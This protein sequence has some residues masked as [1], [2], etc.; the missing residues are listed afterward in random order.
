MLMQPGA[1]INILATHGEGKHKTQALTRQ[2][3]LLPKQF[4]ASPLLPTLR[5]ELHFFDSG[6]PIDRLPSFG[7][8]HVSTSTG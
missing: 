8:G 2:L 4:S 6:D 3:F 5:P 1:G 7:K